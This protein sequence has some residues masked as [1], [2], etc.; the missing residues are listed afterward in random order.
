MFGPKKPAEP[1]CGFDKK[2]CLR[3]GCVHFVELQGKDPQ[4]G[5]TLGKGCAFIANLHIQIAN[6]R[7]MLGM[8]ADTESMRNEVVKSVTGMQVATVGAIES[9]L[10]GLRGVEEAAR[11]AALAAFDRGDTRQGRTLDG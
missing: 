7:L 4:K 1:V 2:P 3:E 5:D 8:Q 11:R 6:N 10:A 9:M